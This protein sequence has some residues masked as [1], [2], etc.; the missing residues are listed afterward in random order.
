MVAKGRMLRASSTGLSRDLSVTTNR[1]FCVPSGFSPVEQPKDIGY[2]AQHQL[3]DQVSQTTALH[4]L[5][6][7]LLPPPFWG[8]GPRGQER[9]SNLS[10][11]L[12]VLPPA[13]NREVCSP[14]ALL[15]SRQQGSGQALGLG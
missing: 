4:P 10:C 1:P 2:L 3:F 5:P 15:T 13:L 6:F 11:F 12:L 8:T 9:G 7:H 14:G